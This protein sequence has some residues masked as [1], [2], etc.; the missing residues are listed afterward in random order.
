MLCKS[1]KQ[2]NDDE[3]KTLTG[4]INLRMTVHA[5]ESTEHQNSAHSLGMYG[6]HGNITSH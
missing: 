5:S 6:L 3:N 2:T 1:D 4:V